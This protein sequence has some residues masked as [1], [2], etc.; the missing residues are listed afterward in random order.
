MITTI[1]FGCFCFPSLYDSFND[2]F[3]DKNCAVWLWALTYLVTSGSS[4]WNAQKN[5]ASFYKNIKVQQDV[6]GLNKTAVGA[7]A[8]SEDK[9]VC[10]LLLVAL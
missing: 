10:L 1:R 3:S 2:K 6:I 4:V 9:K 5:G 7:A 8:V